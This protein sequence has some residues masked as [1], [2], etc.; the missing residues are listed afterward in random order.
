[1]AGEKKYRRSNGEGSIFKHN[2]GKWCGQIAAW[3]GDDGKRHRKSVYGATRAEVVIKL[4]ELR[5]SINANKLKP[6]KDIKLGQFINK[7]LKDIK[8]PTVSPRT[9]EWYVN[10]NKSISGELKDTLILKVSAY[11]I[12]NYL[13]TMKNNKYSVRSVKALYDLLNQVFK[14]A[15]EFNLISKNPLDKVKIT[16]KDTKI[17]QKALNQEERRRVLTAVETH[18]TYKPIIYTM[19]GMGLRIG[20][21]L[22]LTWNDVNFK[23]KTLSVNK[24]AK[25]TPVINDEG[26]IMGRSM[27]ISGTKTACSVRT[28]P[29][30]EVVLEA[31]KEWRKEYLVKPEQFQYANLVFPNK[32]GNLRSYSGF[33]RQYERFLTE[34][35]CEKATFHQFRHTFATM[36]LERGVNPR[37]VQEFLGHKDISTTLGIYTGVTAGT[38][39]AAADGA[40]RALRGII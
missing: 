24:A 34:H 20:E 1:M 37:V 31:L 15:V 35:G 4:A 23:N 25:S 2:N 40:D 8:R 3:V 21:T 26:E 5:G 18:K 7:W 27:E 17:E 13:N 12:Q 14:A 19:I 16:R 30:P 36:M 38:M 29:L 32:D 22:A 6:S 39:K 10:M 33:R 9:Y 28:L 11:Q